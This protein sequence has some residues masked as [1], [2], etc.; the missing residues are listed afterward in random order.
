MLY[1]QEEYQK[2]NFYF[3][4]IETMSADF[5]GYEYFYAL[6]LH[7][8][9]KTEE[10]LRMAQQGISKNAFDVQ[11]LLLASQLS[12]EL[13]D[14]QSAES[15]LKQALP[16]AEDQDEIVLRLSTLYLE[17]E[18]YEDL[19]A[20]ADYEVDSVL[21]RWNIAKAYQALDDEEEA[22]Q[23]YQDLATDLSENP[24]FLHDYA[25]ILREF[26]YRD[27]ARATAEKYLALVPDDVNMQTFLEDY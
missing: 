19:V 25:Y 6:S 24:E 27:Q 5:E 22:F 2:A 17:E 21:A 23:I 12:Y 3:K 9:H 15:Y 8:E 20:L 13:H 14:T 11:L 18:R 16:L 4:Q 1:D 10:A 26:G 7:A